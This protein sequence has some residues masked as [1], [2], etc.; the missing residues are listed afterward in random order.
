MTETSRESDIER[1]RRLMDR[2]TSSRGHSMMSTYS[3]SS[4]TQS[5]DE[6]PIVVQRAIR[7]IRRPDGVSELQ[8]VSSDSRVGGKKMSVSRRIGDMTRTIRRIRDAS[9]VES[10][11]ESVH[12][13]NS[14]AELNQFNKAWQRHTQSNRR[15]LGASSA[16]DKA[17]PSSRSSNASTSRPQRLA[18]EDSYRARSHA[19]SQS[20]TFARKLSDRLASSSD[21][22]SARRS[23]LSTAFPSS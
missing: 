9:G 8:E 11:T 15:R 12:N 22:I 23:S 1:H 19:R 7:Q 5:G 20:S 17:I 16:I 2:M 21:R 13:I 10:Q 6:K 18:I 4:S 14:E 3:F